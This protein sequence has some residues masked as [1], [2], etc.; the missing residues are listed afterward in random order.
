MLKALG[1]RMQV[2][3][4][5]WLDLGK[6]NLDA[7]VSGDDAKQSKLLFPCPASNA[8]AD[9]RGHPKRLALPCVRSVPHAVG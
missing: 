2:G 1:S 4:S 3:P 9:G 7:A 6:V 5:A 8:G